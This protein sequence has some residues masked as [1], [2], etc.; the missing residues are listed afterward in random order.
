[1]CVEVDD[2]DGSVDFVQRAEDRK[3]LRERNVL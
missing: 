2:G 1:M 3:D